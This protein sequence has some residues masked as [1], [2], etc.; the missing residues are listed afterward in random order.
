L[1]AIHAV[2]SESLGRVQAEADSKENVLRALGDAGTQLRRK[3]GESLASIA[4]YD[5]PLIQ[6]TTS[7]L[8][9][10]QAYSMAEQRSRAVDNPG[11]LRYR[12]RAVELDPNF[13]IAYKSLS[14]A[15]LITGEQ[16]A[17]ALDAA[18]KAYELRDRATELERLMIEAHYYRYITREVDKAIERLETATQV[19][20]RSYIAWN[21][22]WAV[23]SNTGQDEKAL[24]AA[25][26][27]ERLVPSPTYIGA[28]ALELFRLGRFAQEKAFCLQADTPY[29]HV[30]S[31][32]I[33]VVEGNPAEQKRQLQR[34]DGLKNPTQARNLRRRIAE[35][36][37]KIREAGS[38]VPGTPS[39]PVILKS[40]AL[41][42]AAA[43][44]CRHAVENARSALDMVNR[45][46]ILTGAG[47]A[48]ALCGNAQETLA[49][50]TQLENLLT[51]QEYN[52][53]LLPCMRALVKASESV[54]GGPYRYPLL[55]ARYPFE[56]A[57]CRGQFYLS[58]NDAAQAR[59][60][61]QL[62][63][64]H[65]AQDPLSILYAVS[66]VGLARSAKLTGDLAASRK[67]YQ[68]FFALW[69]DADRDLPILAE[70]HRE[71]EA[72]R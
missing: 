59:E 22:L 35:F 4:K 51:S 46:D 9:A 34:L 72:L 50:A 19:Y 8:E 54:D 30:D 21:N 64:D 68:D 65:R 10:L 42:Y 38:A 25:R 28:V 57:F 44:D 47:L 43:G 11:A 37:G 48:L 24:A 40:L 36:Q 66:S 56:L 13:A 5:A 14:M 55:Q 29:C 31:Y 7:S 17:P 67:A 12:K 53:A 39:G 27:A 58:R 3:L 16:G 33:A 41:D 61:F 2:S 26:E 69:K 6:A 49:A 1:Q 60:Q 18:R 15:Y 71:F 70:A 23:Y 63:L 20:P 32:L 62:I 52:P 45:S